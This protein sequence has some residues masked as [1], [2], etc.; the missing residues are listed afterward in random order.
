MNPRETLGR[1][2]FLKTALFT[3]GGVTGAILLGCGHE[4]GKTLPGMEKFVSSEDPYEIQVPTSWQR[5]PPETIK[6][7]DS[8][9]DFFVAPSFDNKGVF[10]I[11]K[12]LPI[13][14]WIKLE[15]F[16]N[17][18]AKSQNPTSIEMLTSTKDKDIPENMK[19]FKAIKING[20]AT[21]ASYLRRQDASSQIS[22]LQVSFITDSQSKDDTRRGWT[23]MIAYPDTMELP[24]NTPKLNSL[25]D[26][27][28]KTIETFK[29]LH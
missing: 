27:F 10:F 24:V 6:Q 12:I 21:Q 15:D 11:V 9:I 19:R 7:V 25:Y 1:R 23:M 2:Q 29:L 5:T 13:K 28:Y 20:K 3:T 14:P 18:Q 26:N 4:E 16:A 17:A 22:A 8:N